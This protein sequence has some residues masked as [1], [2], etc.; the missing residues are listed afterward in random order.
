M[1][2]SG[3]YDNNGALRSGS[4]WG[5]DCAPDGDRLG[6]ILLCG[7]L[8]REVGDKA[9]RHPGACTGGEPEARTGLRVP[10]RHG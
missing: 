4:V 8:G 3:R 1:G 7:Q 2:R 5:D 9:R 10:L 6:R